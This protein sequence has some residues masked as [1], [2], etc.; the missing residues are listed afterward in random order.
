VTKQSIPQLL[1]SVQSLAQE[2]SYGEAS[3]QPIPHRYFVFP[4]SVSNGR[5]IDYQEFNLSTLHRELQQMNELS[6]TNELSNMN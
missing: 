1:L 4:L 6:N 3:N 5:D 2:D